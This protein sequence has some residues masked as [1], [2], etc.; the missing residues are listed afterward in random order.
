MRVQLRETEQAF[1]ETHVLARHSRP[2]AGPECDIV[3]SAEVKA[4]H[5][6]LTH[7][8]ETISRVERT[9]L[10][11]YLLEDCHVVVIVTRDL[12]RAHRLFT[13]LN[14]R[15][16]PLDRK[17]ILK[18]EVLRSI[19]D[20]QASGALGLWD[21]C[22]IN[23]GAEFEDFFSYMRS[24]H[25][26]QRL[27]IIAGM[28][29]LVREHGSLAFLG[30]VVTP[31][32]DGLHALRTF[33]NN[34]QIMSSPA[35]RRALVSLDRLG[36]IDWVPPAMLA[37]IA[38]DHAPART[39]ALVVEIERFAFL[40]RLLGL[41]ADKRQRRFQNVIAAIKSGHDAALASS[42]FD[43]SRDEQKTI[44]HHLKNIHR[45]NAPLAKLLLMR[46]EDE[47]VGT[48]MAID[49]ALFSV[50]HVLPLRPA[51]TSN[52]RIDF[53]EGDVRD[54]CQSCL[55]N[56]ALVSVRQND[57]AKN[58]DFAAKLAVYSEMEPGFPTV[59]SNASIYVAKAWRVADIRARE[60]MMLGVIARLWRVDVAPAPSRKT[61]TRA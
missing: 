52:W 28:R 1:L 31:L 39:A 2:A 23:L 44:G 60:A 21:H 40:L 32:A 43:I 17:D 13:V 33:Q 51:Q 6:H 26:N 35:L 48:P 5:D 3:G 47:L 9:R 45:R 24:I 37:M 54:A 36:K 25:G 59:V 29:A 58:K 11:R 46:I 34:P 7:E 15:G 8:V 12:D 61:P 16:K 4:V 53:P 42:A 55:G 19:P 49:P 41:G 57:R 50:E 18:A 56:L 38:F 22:Q 30:N 14:E 10:A 20:D 27:P